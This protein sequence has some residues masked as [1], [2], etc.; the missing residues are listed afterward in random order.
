MN[1]LN[2]KNIAVIRLSSLG[3]IIHT[4]PAFDFLKRKH[5]TIKVNW[6]VEPMGAILLK[7]FKEIDEIIIL[8]LKNKNFFI[9]LKNIKKI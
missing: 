2:Q 3:D 4:L 9:I 7:N 5:P 1:K 8:E 6:I